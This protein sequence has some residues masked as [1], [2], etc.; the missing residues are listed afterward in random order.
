MEWQ[1]LIEKIY[2]AVSR[3]FDGFFEFIDSIIKKIYN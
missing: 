2:L 3:V 1:E